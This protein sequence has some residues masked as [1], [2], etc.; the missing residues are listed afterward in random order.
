MWIYHSGGGHYQSYHVVSSFVPCVVFHLWLCGYLNKQHGWNKFQRKGLIYNISK[1]K[2]VELMWINILY[3][4]RFWVK[5]TLRMHLKHTNIWCISTNSY[6]IN[7]FWN[8]IRQLYGNK[9]MVVQGST[10]TNCC[11]LMIPPAEKFK[12]KIDM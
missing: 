12:L 11:F 3:L 2:A 9:Y 6:F 1:V 5:T 4:F 7:K 8:Q 10:Y